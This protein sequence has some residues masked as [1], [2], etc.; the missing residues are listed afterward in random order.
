MGNPIRRIE[1]PANTAL[2]VIEAHRL[3]HLVTVIVYG[4]AMLQL[5]QYA[6]LRYIKPT[7]TYYAYCTIISLLQ[8]MP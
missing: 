8:Y 6:E 1:S 7:V 5:A 2:Q 3:F 4:K